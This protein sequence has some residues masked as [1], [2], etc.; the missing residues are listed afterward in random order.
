[1]AIT[2]GIAP[3]FITRRALDLQVNGTPKGIHESKLKAAAGGKSAVYG[4]LNWDNSILNEIPVTLIRSAI[5]ASDS[6]AVS[7]DVDRILISSPSSALI[8]STEEWLVISTIGVG[9]CK[10][11]AVRDPFRSL[12]LNPFVTVFVRILHDDE[13][14]DTSH[15]VD[16]GRICC[17]SAALGRSGLPFHVEAPFIP[18]TYDRSIP[19]T[20]QFASAGGVQPA[21]NVKLERKGTLVT[22]NYT[23]IQNW[24]TALLLSIF[25][26]IL[27]RAILQLRAVLGQQNRTRMESTQVSAGFYKYWPFSTRM[28]NDVAK[29]AI[30][31]QLYNQLAK[32]QIYLTESGAS[33]C[34]LDRVILPVYDLPTVAMEFVSTMYPLAQTPIQVAKD[35]MTVGLRPV[36]FTPVRLRDVMKGDA[37]AICNR[38]ANRIDI[39]VPLLNYGTSD[40]V[41]RVP[42][43]EFEKRKLFKELAGFPLLLMADGSV[44]P[45]PRSLREQCFLVPLS[46]LRMFGSRQSQFIHPLIVERFPMFEDPIFLDSLFISKASAGLVEDIAP[47]MFPLAWKRLAAVSAWHTVSDARGESE[48]N[49]S[50]SGGGGVLS[51]LMMYVLW[52]E[53]LSKEPAVAFDGLQS[54]PIVPVVSNGCRLLLSAE[55]LTDVFVVDASPEQDQHRANLKSRSNDVNDAALVEVA[56]QVANMDMTNFT[57]TAG[58]RWASERCEARYGVRHSNPT[59]QQPNFPSQLFD[60]SQVKDS[61]ASVNPGTETVVDASKLVES[62]EELP[63]SLPPA[64][65]PNA[66][67]PAVVNTGM[68]SLS[69]SLKA[70]IVA[71]GVPVLDAGLLDGLPVSIMANTS[72]ATVGRKL[73]NS[74]HSL[75]TNNVVICEAMATA[76]VPKSPMLLFEQLDRLQRQTLL[77]EI[78]KDH[79]NMNF[80]EPE[81]QKFKSLRLFTERG[82]AARS[83]SISECSGGVYWCGSDAALEGI[84]LPSSIAA[85]DSTSS[86]SAVSTPTSML[87][88]FLSK[89]KQPNPVNAR[90]HY[91]LSSASSTAIPGA[92]ESPI[93]LVNEPALREI[94]SLLGVVELS[95]SVAIKKFTVPL[96]NSSA[97]PERM[98]MMMSL[99][100]NWSALRADKELVDSLKDIAFIPSWSRPTHSSSQGNVDAEHLDFSVPPRRP[101]ELLS[102]NNEELSHVISGRLASNYLAPSQMRSVA[103]H[104]MLMDLGMLNDL[105]SS[106]FLQLATDI[107][108]L[109]VN[110]SEDAKLEAASYSRRLLRYLRDESRALDILDQDLARRLRKI[111]FVPALKFVRAES[112]CH[113]I[114]EHEMCSFEQVM[115]RS[116]GSLAFTQYRLLNEDIA[117]PQHFASSLGITVEPKIDVVLQHV[118]ILTGF[119]D[120]IDRWNH[121]FYDA[122]H[123][124]AEI[125][126]YLA[127]N[128]NGIPEQSK[129]LLRSRP[130]IPVGHYLVSSNRLFFRL[131]ED[132]SP[133]MHEVPRLYGPHEH[134]LKKIG[135]K[136]SPSAVDYSHFLRDL[137]SE[138]TDVSLNPNELRAVIAIV[139]IIAADGNEENDASG[140]S[141]VSSLIDGGHSVVMDSLHVPDEKSVMRKA[142]RCIINDDYK[143]RKRMSTGVEQLGYYVLHPN[144]DIAVAASFHMQKLSV[145]IVE[146]LKSSSHRSMSASAS[147][148]AAKPMQSV[149]DEFDI[150]IKFRKAFSSKLFVEGLFNLFVN[151][152]TVLNGKHSEESKVVGS[153]SALLERGTADIVARLEIL[154]LRFVDH[155][156][157][158]LVMVDHSQSPPA[159]VEIPQCTEVPD[160]S[161]LCF[162]DAHSDLHTLY[163]NCSLIKGPVSYELAVASGLTKYLSLNSSSVST[164][165]TLLAACVNM[166]AVGSELMDTLGVGMESGSLRELLRGSPGEC[167]SASDRTLLEL[168]PFRI[169]RVGEVVAYVA[170]GSEGNDM[171]YGRVVACGD[172]EEGGLRRVVVK[173]GSGPAQMLSTEVYSF[174][175]ARE[176][177]SQAGTIISSLAASGSK[178]S[179]PA[180]RNPTAAQAASVSL[181]PAVA[182]PVQRE[183]LLSA[184]TGLMQ[185]AGIPV[186]V[187]EQVLKKRY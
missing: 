58:W 133:F 56:S 7:T 161:N 156:P 163:V 92:V 75:M 5:S 145:M 155:L 89:K 96:L 183:E 70:A 112:G 179:T 105:K 41:R 177:G 24:N 95:V 72:T 27:P 147:S 77:V 11:L 123:T 85:A 114:I 130:L 23:D 181:S 134:F 136:E 36:S 173:T 15:P 29:V 10:D 34:S 185:R 186:T 149:A 12:K 47:S 180:D 87:G 42:E 73:L 117:P 26:S 76:V 182:A 80:T 65:N 69:G 99:A 83:V 63:A 148:A 14:G 113:F 125:F 4:W 187:D 184:V 166:E 9:Q 16:V 107:Q 51:E 44:K 151:T 159:E 61:G 17:G 152:I 39:L 100:G 129:L 109:A 174:K 2:Q 160:S 59:T 111:V 50:S 32:M 108:T 102:W 157:T 86:P 19:F 43:G 143:L 67:V 21:R 90:P 120:T 20:S 135:V 30:H 106:S 126:R 8:T 144:V 53:I 71:L 31:S 115:I 128:W 132:L 84:P 97:P 171:R 104:L 116:K 81:I 119:G 13:L 64:H 127:D 62:G 55:F 6:S 101:S 158:V 110:E 141:R 146:R 22:A 74:I 79:R 164:L 68:Y 140:G 137:S 139:E 153:L 3:V 38:L 169:F 66:S 94:Y 37:V 28:V 98:L 35:L 103:V 162:L 88:T 91:S 93:I 118:S 131:S 124:F 122:D 45:F 154:Q 52:S 142:G 176:R 60:G 48:S 54:W 172:S 33:F 165:S 168:K 138:C 78:Y 178:K 25:E 57:I 82:S 46:I 49:T 150:Q 121:P 170:E 18:I 167:V 175:S 40:I 1:M